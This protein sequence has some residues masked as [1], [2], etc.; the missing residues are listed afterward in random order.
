MKVPYVICD[1]FTDTRFGGNPLAV[2]TDARGVS[3]ADMQRI[4]REF[5]FSETTF[6]L[7]AEQ[8]ARHGATH[9]VR[10]F[11]PAVELPFAGHPNVGTAFVLASA[12]DGHA[13]ERYRF[14]EGAG[15]V[16]VSVRREPDGMVCELAAPEPLHIGETVDIALV[17][18]ACGLETA[19]VSTVRHSPR[20]ASI[21]L[22]FVFMEVV[23]RAAL[24]RAKPR[25]ETFARL[26]LPIGHRAIHLYCRNGAEAIDGR[27]FFEHESV[28]ED[29]ATGSANGALAGL[30]A[31]IDPRADGEMR[32]QAR[33][34]DDMGRP[35]RLS[36]RAVKQRGVVHE[37]YVGGHSVLVAEG[38]LHLDA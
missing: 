32:W 24:A 35:S 16:D 9:R 31:S 21:G 38:V 18:G 15:I 7:P 5:G 19:D 13:V 30:L 25:V 22:P 11:T 28:V 29:P 6:V 14:L 17:A 36:L 2:V 8:G 4:A 3:D 1:V 37:V 26:P 34:G 33:Q 23:D 20:F 10:I 27:M 12:P